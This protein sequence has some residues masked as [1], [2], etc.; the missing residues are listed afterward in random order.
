MATKTKHI[1]TG[2]GG[3]H[4]GKGRI[5]KTATLKNQSKKVRRSQGKAE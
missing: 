5:E 4:C 3:S 2:M 1:K